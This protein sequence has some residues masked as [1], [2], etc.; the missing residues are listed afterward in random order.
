MNFR[1]TYSTA[2][3]TAVLAACVFPLR[4]EAADPVSDGDIEVAVERNLEY[5]Q[6]VAAHLI[7]VNSSNGIVTLSGTVDNILS[8]EAAAES[9]GTI[10]GVHSVVNLIRVRTENVDDKELKSRV[11]WAILSDPATELYDL[12]PEVENGKVVLKG[13]ADSWTE[14]NLAETVVKG[15]AGVRRVENRIDVIYDKRKRTDFE[16]E[17]EI[18][19]RFTY[20]P[21]IR[22]EMISLSVHNG[23]VVL[24]GAVPSEFAR[25]RA[26]SFCWVNGV[27]GVD[28]G[29]L[30]VGEWM[31]EEYRRAEQP[32]NFTD[33]ELFNRVRLALLYDPRVFIFDIEADVV[34]GLVTLSGT[35]SNL[36]AKRSAEE[37]ALNTAGVF[38]VSNAI[39][40]RPEETV[41]DEDLKK[42]VI[43][44]IIQDPFLKRYELKVAVY[45]SEVFLYGTVDFPFEKKHAEQVASRI[46]GVTSVK[47]TITVAEAPDMRTDGKIADEIRKSFYWD[48]MVDEQD[49]LVT[50]DNG[51]AFITGD[52]D[53]FTELHRAVDLAFESGARKVKTKVLIHGTRMFRNEFFRG[54][55]YK[56]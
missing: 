39:K 25:K 34:N 21:Y 24:S 1:K 43:R 32:R 45:S 14:R 23:N 56:W 54:A 50:V 16:I 19:A 52:A 11:E 26:K 4:L 18:R 13:R 51:T 15:V 10:R 55:Y 37:D 9:A 22:E 42:R 6:D 12:D 38:A 29:K 47:N 5:R 3:V 35:V 27:Y 31:K 2:V 28:A 17:E 41:T 36:G 46:K 49:L 44:A 7:D 30:K 33:E 8:R 48:M 20:D 40:V 53:T